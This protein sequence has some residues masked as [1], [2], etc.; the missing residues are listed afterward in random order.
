RRAGVAAERERQLAGEEAQAQ[1]RD[2]DEPRDRDYRGD[3]RGGGP[4]PVRIAGPG[5]A[6]AAGPRSAHVVD[7]CGT[8]QAAAA[9]H[10]DAA[11]AGIVAGSSAPE[12]SPTW[13]RLAALAAAWYPLVV[14][15]RISS[16]SDS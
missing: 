10:H 15:S 2:D 1:P 11:A 9:A 12:E 5:R 3:E 13:R 14:T 4:D 6:C 8:R 7:V 16:W